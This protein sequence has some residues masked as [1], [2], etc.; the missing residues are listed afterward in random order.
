MMARRHFIRAALPRAAA[1]GN[2]RGRVLG[3]AGLDM[4]G[5]LAQALGIRASNLI[6]GQTEPP[7]DWGVLP[8]PSSF[9]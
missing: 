7:S 4:V 6:S 3:S 1:R 2:G 9:L 8:G 5:R